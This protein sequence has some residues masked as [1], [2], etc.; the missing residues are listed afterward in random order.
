MIYDKE[1]NHH[2]GGAVPHLVRG[3]GE[4][5][6]KHPW[7]DDAKRKN[8]LYLHGSNVAVLSQRPRLLWSATLFKEH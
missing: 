5:V 8:S 6:G 1:I 2:T 7:P 4:A 3:R